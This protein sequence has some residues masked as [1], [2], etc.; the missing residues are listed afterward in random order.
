MSVVLETT[1]GAVTLDLY[2]EVRP[3]LSKNF[4]KLCKTKYYNLHLFH[5]VQRGFI[6][7]T[8][9]P[10]GT[11]RGGESIYAA[12]FGDQAKYLEAEDTMPKIK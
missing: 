1:L 2:T 5:T 6:A 10:E 12:V 4:L 9:D 7:Q 11:G 8:G 3:Q